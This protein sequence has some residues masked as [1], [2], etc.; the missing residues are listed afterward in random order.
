MNSELV[1]FSGEKIK[2]ETEVQQILTLLND[3]KNVDTVDSITQG[4]SGIL[5][6]ICC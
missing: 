5:T 4:C 3:E 1:I 6:I 2:V